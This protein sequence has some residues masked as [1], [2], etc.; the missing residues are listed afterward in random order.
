MLGVAGEVRRRPPR[1]VRARRH[2][3]RPLYWQIAG[4]NNPGLLHKHGNGQPAVTQMRA[5]LTEVFEARE[6]LGP[7]DRLERLVKEML[8]ANPH[9]RIAAADVVRELQAEHTEDCRT[10]SVKTQLCR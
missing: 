2:H 4:V 9:Q 7:R 3:P 10:E 8:V 6:S 1:V 5:W